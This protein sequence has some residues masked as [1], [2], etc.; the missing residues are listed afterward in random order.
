[1]GEI[2]VMGCQA[3][4]G[5]GARGGCAPSHVKRGKLKHKYVPIKAPLTQHN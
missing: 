1:M 5:V 2:E 3:A 4:Q